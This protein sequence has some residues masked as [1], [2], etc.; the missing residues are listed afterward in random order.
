M[1]GWVGCDILPTS[2]FHILK[3]DNEQRKL[4]PKMN[5]KVPYAFSIKSYDQFKFQKSKI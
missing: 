4:I 2:I 1:D 5:F 3:Y